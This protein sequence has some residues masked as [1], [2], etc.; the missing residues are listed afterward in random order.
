MIY[1]SHRYMVRRSHKSRLASVRNISYQLSD[2]N[3]T[4][5]PGAIFEVKVYR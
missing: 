5:S 2:S 3:R 1:L 4:G